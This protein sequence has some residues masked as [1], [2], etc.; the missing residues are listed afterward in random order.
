MLSLW[1]LSRYLPLALGALLAL[2]I[3][4]AM[5]LTTPPHAYKFEATLGCHPGD[6]WFVYS[7]I[8][9]LL[10]FTLYRFH[11]WRGF[12]LVA[13]VPILLLLV[14]NEENVIGPPKQLS[15]MFIVPA[16]FFLIALAVQKG[17]QSFSLQAECRIFI[18][19][20]HADWR[21][22]DALGELLKNAL[23]IPP[24]SIRASSIPGQGFEAGKKVEQSIKADVGRAKLTIVVATRNSLDSKWVDFEV[25][26]SRNKISLLAAGLSMKDM[27]GHSLSKHVS[28]S[29]NNREDLLRLVTTTGKKLGVMPRAPESYARYV[30]NLREAASS[31]SV[32][33]VQAAQP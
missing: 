29:C 2:G 8:G 20:S 12:P 10:S 32:S 11:F 27:E 13:L 30:D 5:C 28:L 15:E 18:S 33:A 23:P 3:S 31:Y 26:H 17:L 6:L 14:W 19:H 1:R 16:L 9:I 7:G 4:I 24:E 22:V 25:K 21:I